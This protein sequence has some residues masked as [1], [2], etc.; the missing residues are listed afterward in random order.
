MSENYDNNEIDKEKKRPTF[1]IVLC[2]LSYIYIG[3]SF[4]GTL[5]N[6]TSGPATD[7]ELT[8]V[9]VELTKLV[10]QS[11][12]QG[13]GGMAGYIEQSIE[14]TSE[15]NENFYTAAFLNLIIVV[16][17][18]FA[19]MKMWRGAKLGFHS[20]IVYCLLSTGGIYFYISAANI[21]TPLII[22][23]LIISGVFI[24]LYGLNLKW[25]K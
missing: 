3:F 25:M 8:E 14:M 21:P 12:S 9:K 13:L 19:V 23:N 18:F 11:E 20:Y 7:A 5:L 22:W 24:L 10:S 6:F 16:V 15:V 2:V 4:A 17:G 1:L